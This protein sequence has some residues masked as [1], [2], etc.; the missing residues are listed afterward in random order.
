[1]QSTKY[2]VGG[3]AEWFIIRCSTLDHKV[4]GS[5]SFGAIDVLPELTRN[6]QAL[7]QAT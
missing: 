6:I 2:C 7:V 1:M 5:S 4:M 3:M